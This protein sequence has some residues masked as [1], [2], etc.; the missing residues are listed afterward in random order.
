MDDSGDISPMVS[1]GN[2]TLVLGL[3]LGIFLLHVLLISGFE[4]LWLLKV[5]VSPGIWSN[6]WLSPHFLRREYWERQGSSNLR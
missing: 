2:L 5:I 6:G 4:A 1:I 3:L